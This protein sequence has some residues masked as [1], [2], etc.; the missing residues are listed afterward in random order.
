[1]SYNYKFITNNPQYRQFAIPSVMAINDAFTNEQIDAIVKY[2]KSNVLE[3]A[4]TMGQD[5]AVKSPVRNSQTKFHGYTEETAWI[6]ARLNEVIEHVN[7]NVFNFDLNGYEAFQYTEYKK[8]GE[9]NFHTD[10]ADFFDPKVHADTES[11]KLSLSLILNEPGKDFEGGD[12]QTQ[13]SNEIT[14]HESVKGRMFVFPSYVVHRISPITKGTRKSL[15]VWVKG[16][17]F[18]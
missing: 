9:Y 1:M 17:K 8:N 10:M 2:C 16:P 4:L 6:F 13:T 15:V 11:R 12:F 5:D 18:K 3:K 14:T 7:A